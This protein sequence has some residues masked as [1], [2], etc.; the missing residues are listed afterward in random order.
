[1]KHLHNLITCNVQNVFIFLP[2]KHSN[3]GQS[4]F[5]SN[6]QG[7]YCT[8]L[9]FFNFL[10]L[11]ERVTLSGITLGEKLVRLEAAMVDSCRDLA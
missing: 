10:C 4:I 9:A 1:M 5:L 3:L 6:K 7:I 2:G 11:A 8:R